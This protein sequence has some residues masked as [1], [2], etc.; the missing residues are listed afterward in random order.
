MKTVHAYVVA[1]EELQGRKH[2]VCKHTKLGTPTCPVRELA[3]MDLTAGSLQ[4]V[5]F[6]PTDRR[7]FF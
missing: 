3:W 7:L 1:V 5:V 4:A 6:N 2:I